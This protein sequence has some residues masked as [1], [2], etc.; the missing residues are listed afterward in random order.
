M[1]ME[2]LIDAE[3]AA[4]LLGI[5]VNTLK[6]DRSKRNLCIPYVALSVRVI[7]YDPADLRR[8]VDE[9]RKQPTKPVPRR[10]RGRPT[11]VEEVHARELGIS[12]QELRA[13][14]GS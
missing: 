3:Q 7:R 10:R 12:V 5:S 6:C 1:S 9:R 13:R 14:G 4:Q 8:W 11:R 2:Y